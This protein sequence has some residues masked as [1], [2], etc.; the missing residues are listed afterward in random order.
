MREIIL[1]ICASMCAIIT[2][3][4]YVPQLVKAWR[5]KRTEDL[6]I[7]SWSLWLVSGIIW[8]VYAITDGG[9]ALI[10]SQT[11]ELLM[12]LATLVLTVLYKKKTMTRI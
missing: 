7:G 6:S 10:I 8:E 1:S 2:L 9:I 11:L 5:T 12:I 3:I 4:S